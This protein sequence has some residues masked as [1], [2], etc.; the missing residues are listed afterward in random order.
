MYLILFQIMVNLY[1]DGKR[2][3][4]IWISFHAKMCWLLK[5]P[6]DL[7]NFPDLFLLLQM[8]TCCEDKMKD[9]I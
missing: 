8:C 5:Q 7:K 1:N 9:C 2:L 3:W 6:S 4:V